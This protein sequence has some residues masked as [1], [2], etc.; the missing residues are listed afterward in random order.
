VLLLDL[1]TYTALSHTVS[2]CQSDKCKEVGN[3]AP[4]LHKIGCHGNVPWDIEKRGP[5]RSSTP[6]K[7]SFDVKF[8]KIGPADLEIICLRETIK[9]DKRKK[10]KKLRRVKYIALPATLP[11]GLNKSF[12]SVLTQQHFCKN[13]QNWLMWI[14]VLVCISVSFFLRRSVLGERCKIEA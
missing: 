2:E 1:L 7:L 12:N 6:K 9:K 3:S 4:F 13:Y 5:D 14:E 8:A 11:S 10:K